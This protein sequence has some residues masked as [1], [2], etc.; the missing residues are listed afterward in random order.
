MGGFLRNE[1]TLPMYKDKPYFSPR[2]T[3]PRKRLGA[4]LKV[5]GL[6]ALVL[7]WYCYSS[8]TP[9]W[10]GPGSG[11]KGVE[12]WK[13]LQTLEGDSS[14]KEKPDWELRR[15]K[16]REAFLVSW[17]GYEKEAW[18]KMSFMTFLAP[19]KLTNFSFRLR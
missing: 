3:A 12:L 17:D 13:W 4:F 18:G 6:C 10:R 19:P 2:R 5:L 9:S 7:L 8:R 1:R 16:V 15:E 14:L 11:D